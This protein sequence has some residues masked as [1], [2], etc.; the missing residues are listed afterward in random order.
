MWFTLW[1]PVNLSVYALNQLPSP[2]FA[3]YGNLPLGEAEA[4]VCNTDLMIFES[5]P[6]LLLYE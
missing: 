3:R 4:F 5:K 1:H 2:M 6:G